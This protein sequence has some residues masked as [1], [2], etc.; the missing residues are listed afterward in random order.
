MNNLL[1]FLQKHHFIL[2]FI[3]LEAI[4]IV[5]L[6]RSHT[7]HRAVLSNYSN[8]VTGRI[9]AVN[10]N[11]QS[12][13]GL[14]KQNQLLQE[15]NAQLQRQLSFYMQEV[16]PT[17]DSIENM[18]VFEYIPCR[19]ISNTVQQRNN[20]FILDKG[21]K[22]G[23]QKDMGVIGPDG[24]A[25]IIIGVSN[26]Y[27]TAISLLHRY[28]NLSVRIKHDNQIANLVW[29]GGD[30][31]YAEVV[32]IPT[33]VE[34]NQGDTIVTSGHSFVFPEGMVVGTV[35]EFIPSAQGS[36]NSARIRFATDF[37][38]LRHAFVIHNTDKE[39]LEELSKIRSN[40]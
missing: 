20:Y 7:Y 1:R 29:K 9:Y 36:L 22:D 34:L 27:A 10:A 23:I 14:R 17:Y 8:S 30:Y 38:S 25:G 2:L 16:V 19:V 28:A 6:S 18:A 35:E 15:Q 13:F 39:E 32:D 31:R 40:E 3:L 4:S 21:L 24:V 11:F 12:Y 26:N 33:H 5:L 37:N